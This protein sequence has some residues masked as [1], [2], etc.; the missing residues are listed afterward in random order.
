MNYSYNAYLRS[1]E[2]YSIDDLV[3]TLPVFKIVEILE[4]NNLIGNEYVPRGGIGA[5]R[6]YYY[7]KPGYS[8]KFKINHP[9]H[10]IFLHMSRTCTLIHFELTIIYRGEEETLS[11]FH[12]ELKEL[13][14]FLIMKLKEGL[15]RAR[16][17]PIIIK[18]G[19]S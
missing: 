12:L 11:E 3:S 17:Y 8:H 19:F 2:D 5:N 6:Y 13:D 1:I 14:R 18:K 4:E 9:D 15:K 7:V 16:I 10:L